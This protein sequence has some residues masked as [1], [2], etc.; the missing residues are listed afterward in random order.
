M[1]NEWQLKKQLRPIVRI[2]FENVIVWSWWQEAKQSSGRE[3]NKGGS[4]IDINDLQREKHLFPKC[5][6]RSEKEIVWSWQHDEK[7]SF[8]RYV[9]LIGSAI[10][11]KKEHL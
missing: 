10:D 6:T 2:C 5:S 11:I 9:K 8:G 1:V 7:Q 3:I 4:V